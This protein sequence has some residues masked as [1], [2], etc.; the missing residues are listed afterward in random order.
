LLTCYMTIL[1]IMLQ[2]MW[3]MHSE[4]QWYRR[5]CNYFNRCLIRFIK[6]IIIIII[7]IERLILKRISYLDKLWIYL[8]AGLLRAALMLLRFVLLHGISPFA[9]PWKCWLY[10]RFCAT[11]TIFHSTLSNSSVGRVLILQLFNCTAY[12]R[13]VGV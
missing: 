7:I 10:F 5:E 1:K 8:H 11:V 6:G 12:L 13:F 2:Y 4:K 3:I 9:R